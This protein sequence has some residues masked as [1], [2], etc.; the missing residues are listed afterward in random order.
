MATDELM[1]AARSDRGYATADTY[2][3][4]RF[5]AGIRDPEMLT[6]E[7]LRQRALLYP[8]IRPYVD[9]KI[10]RYERA[11]ADEAKLAY[12]DG[13]PKRMP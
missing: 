4:Q 5:A 1:Q 8:V 12:P 13:T 9:S 10:R 2:L 11:V 6:Q 7:L 3:M